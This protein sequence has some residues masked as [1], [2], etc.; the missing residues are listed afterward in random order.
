MAALEVVKRRLE[1]IG[2]GDICLELHSEMANKKV[3]LA[4]IERVLKL[5][6]P[7]DAD[8]LAETIERLTQVRDSLNQH[9][10]RMHTPVPPSGLT[11]YQVLTELIRLRSEGAPMPEFELSGSRVGSPKRFRRS[12]NSSTTM[13]SCSGRSAIPRSMPGAVPSWKPCSLSTCSD[14][15]TASAAVSHLTGIADSARAL[16]ARVNDDVPT[17]LDGPIDC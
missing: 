11:P 16:A 10:D 4:E 2:L 14:C 7:K 13:R 5:G 15:H 6:K 8:N 3:V 17:T 12:I 9:V 1:K